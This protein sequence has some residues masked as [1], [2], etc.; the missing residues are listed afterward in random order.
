[1]EV[2]PVD[3]LTIPLKAHSRQVLLHLPSSPDQHLSPP[4]LATSLWSQEVALS[5]SLR[6]LKMVFLSLKLG[7]VQKKSTDWI[8]VEAG[9]ENTI[10]TAI[11]KMDKEERVDKVHLLEKIRSL[12][13]NLR[14]KDIM[15][16]TLIELT[17]RP[18]VEVLMKESNIMRRAS[19]SLGIRGNIIACI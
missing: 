2:T 6:Q 19:S 16:E 5:H 15:A 13:R 17:I 1:M 7:M 10:I 11:L 4:L 18:L 12:I 14:V 9:Q 8:A 3:L